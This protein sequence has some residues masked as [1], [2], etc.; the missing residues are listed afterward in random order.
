VAAAVL[1]AL[2][3]SCS[4]LAQDL[5]PGLHEIDAGMAGL[6]DFM[7]QADADITGRLEASRAELDEMHGQIHAFY[8]AVVRQCQGTAASLEA[9]PWGG[10]DAPAVGVLQGGRADARGGPPRGSFTSA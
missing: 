7:M 10:G 9:I 6:T 2:R 4:E 8:T 5:A 3:A 1:E